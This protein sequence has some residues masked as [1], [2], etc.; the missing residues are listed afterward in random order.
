MFQFVC[1]HKNSSLSTCKY[2]QIQHPPPAH[3]VHANVAKSET[4][5]V[6]RLSVANILEEGL[7]TCTFTLKYRN[8]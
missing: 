3:C 5:Q 1:H 4:A 2:C 6:E 8:P 7:S